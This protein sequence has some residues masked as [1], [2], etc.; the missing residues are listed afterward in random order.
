MLDLI[1]YIGKTN[2]RTRSHGLCVT[3]ATAVL[4][5]VGCASSG[6][7]P[8]GDGVYMISKH[9][10]TTFASGDGQQA[11][12]YKEANAYCA[13]LGKELATVDTNATSGVVAFRAASAE[14]HFRCVTSASK[15]AQ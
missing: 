7:I 15:P 12:I 8:I 11:E 1:C 6:V 3:L 13:K 5:I 2:M 9:S 10:A 14:L 4:A